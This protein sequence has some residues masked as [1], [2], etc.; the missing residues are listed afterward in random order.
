MW[1]SVKRASWIAAGL[2]VLVLA[3]ATAALAF[4]EARR[5]LPPIT[6]ATLDRAVPD[7]PLVDQAGRT[8]SLSSFRGRDV[9]LAPTLTLCSEVCPITSGAFIRMRAAVRRAGLG[10]RVA[11]VEVTV[12]PDRDTPSRLRA[13]ERLT[14][15]D[16]PLLT[17]TPA[18]VKRFW[19]FFGVDYLKQPQSKPP[20]RD[21]LSGKPLTYDVAHQDG[22]FLLDATGHERIVI[23][24]PATTGGTLAPQLKRLLGAEGLRNLAHPHGAW[25]VEQAL[26]DLSNLLGTRVTE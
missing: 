22:L 7:V 11:F 19:S 16:W 14:G 5:S 10:S 26:N 24:G 8:V 20:A 9:V 25:T 2:I 18:N 21:W 6:G 13:Y 15:V 12:D 4:V 1:L 23:V 3:A 17:G